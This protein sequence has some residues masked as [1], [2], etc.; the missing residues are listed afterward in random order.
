MK[1][2]SETYLTTCFLRLAHF[3][4][5]LHSDAS[6]CLENELHALQEVLAAGNVNVQLTTRCEW[7]STRV[8]N[9][10]LQLPRVRRASRGRVEVFL[11]L[12]PTD[13][14]QLLPWEVLLSCSALPI[15]LNT[16]ESLQLTHQVHLNLCPSS[17]PRNLQQS[18]RL[19]AAETRL[20]TEF[21]TARPSRLLVPDSELEGKTRTEDGTE[22]TGNQICTCEARGMTHRRATAQENSYRASVS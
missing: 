3:A 5:Q 9:S 18:K 6:G 12:G 16:S 2:E 1:D 10:F 7:N 8:L 17:I 20:G 21:E 13:N 11:S 15:S 14:F 4:T 22:N 19:I